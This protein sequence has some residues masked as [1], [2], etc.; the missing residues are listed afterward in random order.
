MRHGIGLATVKVA[1]IDFNAIGGTM[2][3]I[4]FGLTAC[5]SGCSLFFPPAEKS[6]LKNGGYWLN[7]DAGRRGAVILDRNDNYGYCSEPGPDVALSLVNKIQADIKS[8][9]VDVGSGQ[10]ESAINAVELSGR[11]K[12]VLLAREALY[13]L[14]ELSIDQKLSDA[15]IV[16]MHNNIAK[17]VSDLADA[18]RANAKSAASAV[19][20]KA[21]AGGAKPEQVQQLL[22]KLTAAPNQ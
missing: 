10:L 11:T 20:S 6:D 16:T 19:A 2:R 5:L 12:T 22:E 8:Q 1:A 14:C 9:G 4:I 17:M 13:R 7:Y 21:L 18:E 3:T 15:T